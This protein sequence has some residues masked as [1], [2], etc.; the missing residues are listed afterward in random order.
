MRKHF[1]LLVLLLFLFP[2]CRSEPGVVAINHGT[3]K[4]V[5]IS[6]PLTLLVEEFADLRD[7][8]AYIGAKQDG[9]GTNTGYIAL[10]EGSVAKMLTAYF[11]SAMSLNGY[12]I[13]TEHPGK[14][15]ANHYDAVVRAEII[16]FWFSTY[17]NASHSIK[18]RF[19]VLSPENGEVLWEKIIEAQNKEKLEWDTDFETINYR[20]I[21]DKTTT[22]FLN[23]AVR[24]FASAK[25]AANKK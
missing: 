12:K 21:I 22:D 13:I 1:H 15:I 10:E 17:L 24:E 19:F 2:G 9:F 11:A 20:E 4:K 14:N 25:I 3:I 5:K 8:P 7:K 23:S 16:N 6:K 18:V